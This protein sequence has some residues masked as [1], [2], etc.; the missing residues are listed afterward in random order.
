MFANNVNEQQ[1]QQQPI[2]TPV[3]NYWQDRTE[4]A[5]REL[6]QVLRT[7]R[8]EQERKGEEDRVL[9]DLS[10]NIRSLTQMLE[11]R[12]REEEERER[13]DSEERA[14]SADG[15]PREAGDCNL[16]RQVEIKTK[17]TGTYR[18]FCTICRR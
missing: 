7:V 16:C 12:T 18:D 3:A 13:K 6:R 17:G 1:Q 15:H 2:P 4:T 8:R 10:D 14:D 5:E 9:K 11:T